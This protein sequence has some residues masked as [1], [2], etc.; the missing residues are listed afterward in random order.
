[1]EKQECPQGD[2]GKGEVSTNTERTAE[3]EV[4]N[5]E[6]TMSSMQSPSEGKA[7][8]GRDLENRTTRHHAG[9]VKWNGMGNAMISLEGQDTEASGSSDQD[10]SEWGIYL[11]YTNRTQGQHR[12]ITRRTQ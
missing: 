3:G 1:M 7:K 2:R 5:D 11:G 6:M 12:W 9:L 8:R 10:I 4:D